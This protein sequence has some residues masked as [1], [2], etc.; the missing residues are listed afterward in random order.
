MKILKIKI[1][2]GFSARQIIHEGEVFTKLVPSLFKLAS[3]KETPPYSGRLEFVSNRSQDPKQAII[4][5]YDL[6]QFPSTK[7]SIYPPSYIEKK[8]NVGAKKNLNRSST[9]IY[10]AELA[11]KMKTGQME[12]KI[13]NV[14]EILEFLNSRTRRGEFDSGRLNGDN[15]VLSYGGKANG[16]GFDFMETYKN[17]KYVSGRCTDPMRKPPFLSKLIDYVYDKY[18]IQN[19]VVNGSFD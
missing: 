1:D 8:F 13:P 5:D 16:D 11:E 10:F 17:G 18:K 9:Y 15:L 19:I 12:E 4:V 6:A 14:S 3:H 2:A 7:Y